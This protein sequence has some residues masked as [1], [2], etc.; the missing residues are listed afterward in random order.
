M[1]DLDIRQVPV[2][3]DN[4][5]Y[6]VRDAS[7]GAVAVVDP[8]VGPPVLAVAKKLDWTITHILITHPHGDHVGGVADI[9][10]ATG[11]RVY[12][13]IGD[14]N[15]IPGFDEGLSDGDVVMVGDAKARVLDI[16]G[17]TA[18]HVAYW[19]EGGGALFCGDTLFSLGCGRLFGGTAEQMWE[20]LRKLRNLPTATQVYPAHEYTNAN[21]DFALTI[22]KGNVDLKARAKEVNQL[23]EAGK[24][25]VPVTLESEIKCNPFLR[26]DIPAVQEAVNMAGQNSTAV[27]A[28]IRFRKDRF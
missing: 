11:A 1:S 2:L 24:P 15:T 22:E 12:G 5:V 9:K 3:N 13:A 16:P 21:A 7:S 14:E 4:Y 25:T 27:F 20:S 19:F 8:A 6:L 23:R 17:H 26:A 18:N 28:E 10:A